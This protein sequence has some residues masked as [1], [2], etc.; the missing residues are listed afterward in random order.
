MVPQRYEISLN[1]IRD[2]Q[3][4]LAPSIARPLL[5]VRSRS[6]RVEPVSALDDRLNPKPRAHRAH[7]LF[8]A[9][10]FNP[11]NPMVQ[12]RRDDPKSQMVA[13]LKQRVSK[14]DGVSATGK[15]DED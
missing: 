6:R 4:K 2:A 3:Q 9:I 11:A 13:K 10:G 8:I 5:E 15:S 1:A 12:M 7:E 14:R